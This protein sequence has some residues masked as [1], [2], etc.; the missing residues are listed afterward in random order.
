MVSKLKIKGTILWISTTRGEVGFYEHYIYIRQPEYIKFLRKHL[1]RQTFSLGRSDWWGR[2]EKRNTGAL[3]GIL[4]ANGIFCPA[5]LYYRV[6]IIY[7][8]WF[9]AFVEELPQIIWLARPNHLPNG[10]IL[11]G[12][13]SFNIDLLRKINV[14]LP[15]VIL[16]CKNWISLHFHQLV[17]YIAV[18]VRTG[19]FWG[20]LVKDRMYHNH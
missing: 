19:G 17:Q 7:C 3:S 15:K 20:F 18:E 14:S 16:S 8:F 2:Q 6:E 13:L 1:S 5:L 4:L 10:C 11:P 9:C 12:A